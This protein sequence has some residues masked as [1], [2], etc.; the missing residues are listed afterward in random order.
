MSHHWGYVSALFAALLFGINA[1][2]SKMLLE[3]AHPLILASLFYIFSGLAMLVLRRPTIARRI[4]K[5]FAEAHNVAEINDVSP[6]VK[7]IAGKP[8]DVAPSSEG[9]ISFT[10]D[11]WKRLIVVSLFGAALGPAMFMLGLNSTTAINASLLAN[12][13]T[14]FT[15]LLAFVIFS[16]RLSMRESL[17]VLILIICA[18][19]ITTNLEFSFEGLTSGMAGNLL[20]IGAC[21]CWAID[22]NLSKGL[23]RRNDILDV[24]SVKSI[25]GGTICFVFAVALGAP[26]NIS[27]VLLLFV[28]IVGT[29]CYG[30]SLAFFMFGLRKIGASRT[31]AIFATSSF[32]SAGLAFVVLHEGI[33]AIEFLS[34]LGML[35]GVY[36]LCLKPEK[37][38]QA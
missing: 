10:K 20:I 17:A 2:A 1:T 37:K 24:V 18:V 38:P 6:E 29:L 8:K 12:A 4:E 22:N 9:R 7:D 3:E 32:F 34:G 13:E 14:V 28:A 31:G 11:D 5:I 35:V 16:E 19:A 26:M 23:G 25:M 21:L 27:P 30:V 33:T 36:T 15:I